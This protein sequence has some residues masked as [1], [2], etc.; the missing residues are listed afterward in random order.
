MGAGGLGL[1]KAQ[2]LMGWRQRLERR[3]GPCRAHCV[4]I[5]SVCTRWEERGHCGA[6]MCKWI[7]SWTGVI[8]DVV[9]PSASGDFNTYLPQSCY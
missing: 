7:R 3:H 9:I 8:L 2:F 1:V 5:V 6:E 4:T